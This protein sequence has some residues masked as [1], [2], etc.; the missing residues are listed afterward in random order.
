MY[1]PIC[2]FIFL[3]DDLDSH[4]AVPAGRFPFLEDFDTPVASDQCDQNQKRA[5]QPELRGQ[6]EKHHAE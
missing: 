4:G 6:F 2:S 3:V 1:S 5:E